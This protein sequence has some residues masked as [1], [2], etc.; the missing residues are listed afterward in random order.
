MFHLIEATRFHLNG[1]LT[2]HDLWLKQKFER[3]HTPNF[4]FRVFGYCFSGPLLLRSHR[5]QVI[6]LL[7]PFPGVPSHLDYTQKLAKS[8][9]ALKLR[10][11]TCFHW[12]TITGE[13]W[14]KCT[15]FVYYITHRIKR[16]STT[17][18]LKAP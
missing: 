2:E 5:G 17:H 6:T 12:V 3:V 15:F 11:T 18:T 1:E 4:L 7:E 16:G 13:D 10:V 14:L 8:T 9:L